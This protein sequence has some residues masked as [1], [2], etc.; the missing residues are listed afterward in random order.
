MKKV[1]V[2]TPAVKERIVRTA[3]LMF[4][5]LCQAAGL[6]AVVGAALC[7]GTWFWS[8]VDVGNPTLWVLVPVVL[9][10]LIC[11]PAALLAGLLLKG[12]YITLPA[13]RSD[14]RE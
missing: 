5:D 8:L 11:G 3:I 10:L 12:Q 6:L 1:V 7:T 14:R 4:A 13:V 9:F 2:A